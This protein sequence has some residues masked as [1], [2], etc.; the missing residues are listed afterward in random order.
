M[1]PPECDGTCSDENGEYRRAS[2]FWARVLAGC[3]IFGFLVMLVATV[4]VGF[5]FIVKALR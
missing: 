3:L 4:A 5:Y 1:S 2:R